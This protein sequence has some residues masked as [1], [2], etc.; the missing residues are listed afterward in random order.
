M[1]Y[2]L[3]TFE[4][5]DIWYINQIGSGNYPLYD[6]PVVAAGGTGYVY[7]FPTTKE[8]LTAAENAMAEM[9]K[10]VPGGIDAIGVWNEYQN[11][12]GP[13]FKGNYQ[14]LADF[15]K[16]I[17]KGVKKGN[18]EV[19]VSGMENDWWGMYVWDDLNKVLESANGEP[20]FD[21][22]SIHTYSQIQAQ[23]EKGT[24]RTFATDV[25]SILEKYG[26]NTEMDINVTEVG[27]SETHVNFDRE[28]HAA[29]AVRN[30]AWHWAYDVGDRICNYNLND[31]PEF[32]TRGNMQE[33]R[34][35]LMESY[36]KEGAEVPYLG[37]EAF[38]AAGYYNN[39]LADAEFTE[40]IDTGYT[41]EQAY[42][43]RFRHRDGGDVLMMGPVENESLKF[44]LY[45]GTNSVI[46][47]DKYGNEKEVFGTDGHFNFLVG[48]KDILYVRGNFGE[49]T[50]G[51]D[52]FDVS[53]LSLEVPINYEFCIDVK[54]PVD[55]E[56]EVIASNLKLENNEAKASVALGNAT[57]KSTACGEFYDGAETSLEVYDKN[58][59]LHFF[60]TVPINYTTSG[61]IKEYRWR[62]VGSGLTTWDLQVE[63][64]NVREDIPILGTVETNGLSYIVPEIAPK[65]LRKI[66]IPT[67]TIEKASELGKFS[68][69][70]K[71]TTG[72]EIPI[73]L[74]ETM[75]G[76]VYT[77]EKPVI[78]GV[79]SDGEWDV[80]PM[81]LRIDKQEQLFGPN[82]DKW[83]GPDDASMDAYLKY[84]DENFYVAAVVK[85]DFYRQINPYDGMW[86]GDSLQVLIGFDFT[87]S[88]TQYGIGL[89]DGVTPTVYRNM[90]EDNMGGMGGADA[91]GIY[92]DGEI[93]IT[94]NGEYTI[95]EASFPWD[96]IKFGGGNVLQ[97]Q[98][99]AFSILY[100]DDD[101][102]NRENWIEYA[103]NCIGSGGNK[104]FEAVSALLIPSGTQSKAR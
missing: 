29:Y 63:I 6:D 86:N 57:V 18:P 12:S 87:D 44:D 62:P 85:D 49:I 28:L 56:G 95:Y 24:G 89:A 19:E 36:C 21:A 80:G 43:Y 69:T 23:P 83:S 91:K 26:L 70:L 13:A 5:N 102:N 99:I 76:M 71:L 11:M 72:D 1:R 35:G 59:K 32:N 8:G 27:W 41:E 64:E 82:L 100:N 68:G 88:G 53:D 101:G 45:L 48:G 96:K 55:F 52:L 66:T 39:L 81:A 42:A 77:D 7:L 73:E 67:A 20:V 37:K 40:F 93:A 4:N 97:G 51:R 10:F 58:G 103:N 78:D 17:Y 34:F 60:Y 31:Y 47:G 104:N 3:V 14:Y 54:T 30:Q 2:W 15:H 98:R 25:R 94:R 84:D 92:T 9:V 61:K 75:T 22:M 46:V 90:Q 79:I 38:V 74:N 33:A 16:A 65:E 50:K